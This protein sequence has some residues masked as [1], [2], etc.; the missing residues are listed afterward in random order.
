MC[1]CGY[2][3]LHFN[4]CVLSSV[5]KWPGECK[6]LSVRLKLWETNWSVV[7]MQHSQTSQS[8][9]STET[10]S[11][12]REGNWPSL[13]SSSRTVILKQESHLLQTVMLSYCMMDRFNIHTPLRA[14]WFLYFTSHLIVLPSNTNHRSHAKYSVVPCIAV[15][16]KLQE[17]FLY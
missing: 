11:V 4:T 7:R 16:R 15:K 13:S 2:K 17:L 9:F 5:C 1:V 6:R 12:P 3:S 10:H 14:Y 8:E